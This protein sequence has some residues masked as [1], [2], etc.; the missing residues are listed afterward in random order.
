MVKSIDLRIFRFLVFFF[1]KG[2]GDRNFCIGIRE[3]LRKVTDFCRCL[4]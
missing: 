4:R 2:E 1:V 3:V